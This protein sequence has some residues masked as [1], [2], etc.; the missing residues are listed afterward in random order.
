MTVRAK[1]AIFLLLGLLLGGGLTATVFTTIVIPQ[2]NKA[3]DDD[4]KVIEGQKAAIAIGEGAMK[5]VGQSIQR[6]TEAMQKGA[7]VVT[8]LYDPKAIQSLAL[9]GELVQVY[10][11]NKAIPYAGYPR[12][13]IPGKVKPMVA[14]SSAQVTYSYFDLTSEKYE[15]PFLP[16]FPRQMPQ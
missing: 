3:L 8:L 14:G 1:C 7:S 11:S 6:Q 13:I 2:F 10:P 9:A 15:G 4:Q 5:Q 16:D 12:W